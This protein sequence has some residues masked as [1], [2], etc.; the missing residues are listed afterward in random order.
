MNILLATRVK[1]E[2][3]VSL[4]C[5]LFMS[6]A[7]QSICTHIQHNIIYTFSAS[8]PEEMASLVASSDCVVQILNLAL[9][10]N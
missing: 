10:L 8:T 2:V 4:F 7:Y 6:I 3:K 5:S 9:G 1:R